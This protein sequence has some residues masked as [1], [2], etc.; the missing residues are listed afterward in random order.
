MAS[1]DMES[2]AK[3]RR[4]APA[5]TEKSLEEGPFHDDREPLSL[6][7]RARVRAAR[8]VSALPDA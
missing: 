3:P 4:V 1:K 2:S 5:R 6:W 8:G 7:E